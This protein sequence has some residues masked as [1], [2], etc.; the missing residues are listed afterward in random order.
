MREEALH[1]AVREF[2]VESAEVLSAEIDGG[3]ELPF[4][5]EGGGAATVLYQYVPLTGRFIENRWHELRELRSY[6]P[7]ARALEPAAATYLRLRGRAG[8]DPDEAL[9]DL[10]ERLHDGSTSFRF[11]EERFAA[12]VADLG[13]ARTDAAHVATVLAPVHGLRIGPDRIAVEDGLALTSADG[14][15]APPEALEPPGGLDLGNGVKAVPGATT[16]TVLCVFR[17]PLDDGAALPL[18]EA[19]ARFRRLLRGVR[20][21]GASGAAVGPLAWAR[22][23]R[24]AWHSLP[25]SLYTPGRADWWRLD[26]EDQAA[27]LRELLEVLTRRGQRGAVGWALE[28]FEMG[29][30]R[31]RPLQALTDH[32]LALRALVADPGGDGVARRIAAL[33]AVEGDQSAVEERIELACALER[34]VIEGTGSEPIDGV[35]PGELALELQE[36]AR[37]LL[38]DLLCGYLDADVRRAADEILAPPESEAPAAGPE[39][40]HGSKPIWELDTTEFDAIRVERM[41]PAPEPAG[42]F[43]HEPPTE[44]DEDAAQSGVTASADWGFD[45]DPESY[46]APV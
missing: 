31:A 12:A 7:A 38:R 30:E 11:S 25:L 26:R 33:C 18:P 16:P 42:R 4:E 13:R 34:S 3:A 41:E 37:A 19:R 1:A 14:V 35:S 45:E 20:L 5:V 28:R 29:C 43:R 36:H 40:E 8:A 39:S 27:E 6:E 44:A 32:L 23:G 2:A 10:V 9:R 21:A 46:S 17:G 24:G 15:E 22:V